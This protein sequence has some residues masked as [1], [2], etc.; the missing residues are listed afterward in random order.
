MINQS[1]RFYCAFERDGK[2]PI[3]IRHFEN[4]PRHIDMLR[5]DL[6]FCDP[7]DCSLI[8]FP[9]FKDRDGK[10][11]QNITYGRWDSFSV[12]LL[13]YEKDTWG[14]LGEWVTYRHVNGHMGTLEKQTLNQFLAAHPKMQIV[15]WR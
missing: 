6:A 11:S 3:R 15:G 9:I 5:Y 12:K 7:T 4:A 2:T 10:T 8:V 1:P 13:E 14:P